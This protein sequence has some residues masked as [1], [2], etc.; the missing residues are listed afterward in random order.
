[1]R[2]QAIGQW[3]RRL[4]FFGGCLALCKSIKDPVLQIDIR[5]AVLAVR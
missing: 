5:S 2:Q 1:M 3:C 4:A